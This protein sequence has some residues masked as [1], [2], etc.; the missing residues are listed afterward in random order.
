M[1]YECRHFY[2]DDCEQLPTSLKV[3]PEL[4][5]NAHEAYEHILYVK[6]PSFEHIGS[7]PT[8]E[9]LLDKTTVSIELPGRNVSVPGADESWMDDLSAAEVIQQWH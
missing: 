4:L 1:M 7:P 9:K 2:E 5:F 6:F 8:N 3:R